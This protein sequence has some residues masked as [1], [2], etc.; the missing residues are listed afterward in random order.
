MD[1]P[2]DTRLERSILGALI[3]EPQDIFSLDLQPVD[4]YDGRNKRLYETILSLAIESTDISLPN[5]YSQHNKLFGENN[6]ASYLADVMDEP[7]SVSIQKDADVL[8]ELARQR[9]IKNLLNTTLQ[10]KWESADFV[11][12]SLQLGI[13]KNQTSQKKQPEIE[14]VS[15]RLADQIEI[16]ERRGKIGEKTGFDF[17][18]QAIEGFIQS[19]F[20]VV[21]AYTSSG[22]SAMMVQLVCNSLEKNQ[23]LKPAIFSTEMTDEGVLLRFIANRTKIPTFAILKGNYGDIAKKKI[24]SALEYFH[25]KNL[26]IYDDVYTFE[27]IFLKCKQLK[28]TV[29]LDVVYIDFLQNMQ[30]QGSIYERMSVLPIQLQ[31]MAKDLNICVV[32]MSQVSNETAQNNSK[33]I[34]YKGAGEIAAACDLGLWLERDKTD[35]A[36]LTCYIRKNRHGQTFKQELRF[37]DQFTWIKEV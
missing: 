1:L 22:K 3:S 6:T 21:G 15:F 13:I 19:H 20:W 12:E 9:N 31:K 14:K 36:R 18:D 27:A 32:A 7:F 5:I 4:F 16:N 24:N 10:S 28:M 30:G 37:W 35:I 25:D 8:K 2:S 11:I 23:H 29:G 26:W 34:G 17:L 33:I